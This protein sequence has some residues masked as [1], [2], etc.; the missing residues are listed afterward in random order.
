MF[1]LHR[2]NKKAIK[3]EKTERA[4]RASVLISLLSETLEVTKQDWST[5]A[6]EYHKLMLETIPEK[7]KKQENETAKD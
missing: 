7:D 1:K 4:M 5:V 3:M 6:K 2:Q